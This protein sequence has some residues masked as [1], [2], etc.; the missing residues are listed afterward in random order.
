M[1]DV[2]V[3]GLL[4]L[5]IS[6]CGGGTSVEDTQESVTVE[7]SDGSAS[8]TIPV[9]AI[10]SGVNP[11]SITMARLTA[12]E[13]DLIGGGTAIAA[14]DLEPDG[15]E[16]SEPITL[17]LRFLLIGTDNPELYVDSVLVTDI[18]TDGL[19]NGLVVTAEISHFSTLIVT[20]GF[21]TLA[22]TV[23]DSA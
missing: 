16:F 3:F 1:R 23:P 11:S 15:L 20:R 4:V 9:G 6:A 18:A 13:M 2:L 5:G 17:T 22:L 10:P 21:F 8:L 12:E 14:Y 19:T 7:S